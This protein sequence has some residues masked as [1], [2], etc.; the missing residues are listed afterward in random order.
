VPAFLADP[1]FSPSS[2]V[3]DS[4]H[5]EMAE[6]EGKDKGCFILRRVI[7]ESNLG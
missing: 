4:K 7:E 3:H 2:S 1:A 5:D 6:V